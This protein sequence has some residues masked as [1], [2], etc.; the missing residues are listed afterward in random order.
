MLTPAAALRRRRFSRTFHPR[1]MPWML[2]AGTCGSTAPGFREPSREASRSVGFN[3]IAQQAIALLS[4]SPGPVGPPSRR[5]TRRRRYADTPATALL[6]G[7][8][9][10]EWSPLA[11]RPCASFFTEELWGS[12]PR[13]GKGEVPE[14]PGPAGAVSPTFR[15]DGRAGRASTTAIRL[16]RPGDPPPPRP[17]LPLLPRSRRRAGVQARG[18]LC[19]QALKG[20]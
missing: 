4:R 17:P 14:G 5:R 13:A 3:P 9:A 10:R 15:A 6:T 8:T 11:L 12:A 1:I 2:F 19:T 20:E 16:C 18:A 7:L